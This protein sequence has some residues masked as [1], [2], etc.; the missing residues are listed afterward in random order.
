MSLDT[1]PLVDHYLNILPTSFAHTLK[2]CFW[3][4]AIRTDS[5]K[6]K[7][8]IWYFKTFIPISPVLIGI[9]TSNLHTQFYIG[10]S[11]SGSNLVHFPSV[12][13]LLST[14]T[15]RGSS[16][17]RLDL[18]NVIVEGHDFAHKGPRF[19]YGPSWAMSTDT[20]LKIVASLSWRAPRRPYDHKIGLV[21][22]GLYNYISEH[23]FLFQI[24]NFSKEQK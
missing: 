17:I 18:S 8:W 21:D 5:I 10:M 14:P 15:M 4:L 3:G 1:S 22:M 9:S 20:I 6:I 2:N 12:V 23:S 11:I 19:L 7:R 16:T 13:F 24:K